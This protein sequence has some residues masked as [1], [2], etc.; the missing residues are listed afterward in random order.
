MKPITSLFV[1]NFILQSISMTEINIVVI[2]LSKT[3]LLILHI[4]LAHFHRNISNF[5][6]KSMSILFNFYS[7]YSKFL[8]LMGK[9]FCFNSLNATVALI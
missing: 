1:L 9:A 7:A 4:D 3:V 5:Y 8:G 6:V 2:E